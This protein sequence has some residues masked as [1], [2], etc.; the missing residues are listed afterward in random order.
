M[1]F[2]NTKL[3]VYSALLGIFLSCSQTKSSPSEDFLIL[4]SVATQNFLSETSQIEPNALLYAYSSSSTELPVRFG[5]TAQI[6][7]TTASEKAQ[8]E[9]L[10]NPLPESKP[11]AYSLEIG[12]KTS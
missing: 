8:I 9:Y 3:L 4:P 1:N 7:N 5:M 6:E 12:S 11:E 2:L 10:I